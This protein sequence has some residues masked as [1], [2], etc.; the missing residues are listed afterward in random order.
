MDG[1]TVVVATNESTG[2][3]TVTLIDPASGYSEVLDDEPLTR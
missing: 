3:E 2:R 1:A